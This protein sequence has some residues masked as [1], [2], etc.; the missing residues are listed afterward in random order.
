M[1]SN[2][3]LKT[4]LYKKV[5]AIFERIADREDI[6]FST[7][8]QI[9]FFAFLQAHYRK[10]DVIPSRKY[11]KE[12]FALEKDNPAKDTYRD[13]IKRDLEVLVD[14]EATVDLQI[15]EKLKDHTQ[16]LVKSFSTNIKLGNP[17][18]LETKV[19]ELQEDLIYV[20]GNLEEKKNVEGLLH[21]KANAKEK[22]LAKYNKR[23]TGEGYYVAKTGIEH[24]DKTIGGIHSVDFLSLVGYTKQ[25]KS[26]IARQ[27]GYNITKQGKN[28]M[29]ITLEMSY[30]DIENHFYTLHANNQER[31]GYEIPKITNKAVKEATLS[32]SDFSFFEEVVADYTGEDGTLGTEDLGSVYIKQPEGIY[33]LDMLKSDVKKINRNIFPV[34]V[35]IIDGVALMYPNLKSRKSREEMNT[36]IADIRSFGLTFEQGQGL[37]IIAPFQVN[38]NGYE[39]MLGNKSNLYDLTAISEYNEIERSSTHIIS[40]AVTKDMKDAGELQI[41]HLASRETEQFEAKKI[42]IDGSTGVFIE[43]KGTYTEEDVADILEELE[44]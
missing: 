14:L 33:T 6:V 31:F 44:I 26:T 35:L 18:E 8:S 29:F 39:M 27:I 12:F 10:H 2:K 38:R 20:A 5:T 25:F 24:I 11:C 22:Y 40:T 16:D 34:D 28:V 32:A 3:I 41:Q 19:Q 30:D 7:Q 37:P 36:F 42:S 13:I 17:S 9:D 15:R 1:Y 4:I 43:T 21:A 23:N